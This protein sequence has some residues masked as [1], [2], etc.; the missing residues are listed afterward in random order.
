MIK[1]I[2]LGVLI[3]PT[4]INYISSTT[5]KNVNEDID[6]QISIAAKKHKIA[7]A[8][9][10]AIIKQESNFK[11][12]AMRYEPH[13]KRQKWYTNAL[14]AKSKTNDYAYYSMGLM[15]IMYGTARSIGYRGKPFDMINPVNSINYG[16]KH[17]KGL[18][19]RYWT[20]EKVISAYNQGSPRKDKKT[21][22]F[23]NQYYVNKVMGYYKGYNP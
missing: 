8:L 4:I 18:I 5:N 7:P 12:A 15:Q 1:K 13:L 20:I 3:M 22:K 11:I 9:I 14:D 19:K 17:L 23:K 6:N 16:C 10:K 21:G 2:I